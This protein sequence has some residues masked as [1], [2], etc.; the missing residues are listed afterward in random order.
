MNPEEN[1]R[2]VAMRIVEIYEENG[3]STI[4][5]I[6]H[7]HLTLFNVTASAVCLKVCE[8]DIF[9]GIGQDFQSNGPAAA[10]RMLAEKEAAGH[11]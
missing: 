6:E 2:F 3:F 10:E 9:T 5:M 1:N 7:L 8:P 11:A 4:E